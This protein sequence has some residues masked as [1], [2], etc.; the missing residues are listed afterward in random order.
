MR[1]SDASSTA[2]DPRIPRIRAHVRSGTANSE[3]VDRLGT[4]TVVEHSVGCES[5]DLMVIVRGNLVVRGRGGG[6]FGIICGSNLK[7]GVSRYGT[8]PL[9]WVVPKIDLD[10]HF[11]QPVLA[12]DGRKITGNTIAELGGNGDTGGACRY[13]NDGRLTGT[14]EA[15]PVGDW[16]RYATDHTTKATRTEHG[17]RSGK[18]V[19]RGYTHARKTERYDRRKEQG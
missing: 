13:G 15:H 9:G 11:V 5:P 18:H 12:K 4:E 10:D 14:N 3:G 19:R 1:N 7:Q 6:G 16:T 17:G 2:L 8:R